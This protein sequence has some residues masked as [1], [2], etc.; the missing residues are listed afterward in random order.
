VRT[1]TEYS[2]RLQSRRLADLKNKTASLERKVTQS[3][4]PGSRAAAPFVGGWDAAVAGPAPDTRSRPVADAPPESAQARTEVLVNRGRRSAYAPGL[5]RR[6]KL[7]L[8]S[9]LAT[10]VL[11]GLLVVLLTSG[12]ASWPASVTQVQAETTRACQNPDVV[13][14]PGQ[15]NFAC[16][17][18]AAGP[19]FRFLRRAW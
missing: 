1:L 10:A 17:K 12:G 8:A 11:T 19:G 3:G 15:V 2:S 5:S 7:A 14:D 13:S 16:A 9:A 4:A 18:A 6:S